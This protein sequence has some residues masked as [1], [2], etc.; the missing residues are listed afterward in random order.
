MNKNQR[1][2]IE[3][4][5][6]KTE[7]HK[8]DWILCTL[9]ENIFYFSGF[10]TTFYTRFIGVLVPTDSSLEPVLTAS[11]IDRR[12]I[13][14]DLWSRTWF[15]KAAIWGPGSQYATHWDV[16]KDHLSEGIRLGVDAIQLDFYQQLLKAFPGIEVV[17]LTD[18]ILN[19][20]TVKDENEIETIKKA[21]ALAEDVMDRVPDWLA[22]PITEADLAAELNYCALKSGAE[23]I[24]YPTLV[25][26][27]EKMLAFHSPPLNRPIK[28]NELI[29]IAFGLQIDGYGSD[30]V[31]HFCIGTLPA[32]L[33]PLRK[34]F[35]EV[36]RIIA[37]TIR[38][39][40]NSS[41][42]LKLVEGLYRERGV[43]DYWLHNIGHGIALTIHEFPRIA[44][45]D[46]TILRENMVLAIEP[47]LAL[48][49]YGAIAHCDGVRLTADGCEWLSG[50]HTDVIVI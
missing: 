38:P 11:F 15:K 28:E 20:R 32:E 27:G 40:L 37:D 30:I 4:L 45:A 16:L 47:I 48:P 3:R 19:V 5:I 10:R 22:A 41:D 39:G 18:E 7:S 26:C 14:T 2:R 6:R 29:R 9:P 23:A 13:E 34:A 12:L 50:R 25:S 46:S 49:P 44:G 1:A 33:E 36:R 24:F 35:Y 8:L 31:R 17:N 43:V 42:L 21:F